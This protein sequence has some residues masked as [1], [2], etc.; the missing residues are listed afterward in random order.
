MFVPIENTTSNQQNAR[1]NVGKGGTKKKSCG[2]SARGEEA[3]K[4][5]GGITKAAQ[6]KIDAW[7]E[8]HSEILV[9]TAVDEYRWEECRARDIVK[10]YQQ[11]LIVKR[12]MK[13]WENELIPCDKV[14]F[15][16]EYHAHNEDFDYQSDMKFL[17]GH[18]FGGEQLLVCG[19]DDDFDRENATFDAVKKRFGSEFNEELWNTVRICFVEVD[20]GI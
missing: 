13:D 3:K 20:G 5:I 10:A 17:C 11:F 7:W 1:S 15:M 19:K 12:E 2:G 8:Q 16:M 14:A 18:D 4:K 6:K 9:K